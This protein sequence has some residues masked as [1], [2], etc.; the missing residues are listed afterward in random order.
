MGRE[1]KDAKALIAL[2]FIFYFYLSRPNWM[3]L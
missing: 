2:S 1:E 3:G